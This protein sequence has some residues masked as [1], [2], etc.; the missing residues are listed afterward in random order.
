MFGSSRLAQ[1]FLSRCQ[2][3]YREPCQFLSSDGWGAVPILDLLS[4]G[5]KRFFFVPAVSLASSVVHSRRFRRGKFRPTTSQRSIQPPRSPCIRGNSVDDR[6]HAFQGTRRCESRTNLMLIPR[7]SLK[8]CVNEMFRIFLP[9]LTL[10]T[11][12]LQE[13]IKYSITLKYKNR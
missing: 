13:R 8:R 9:I 6:E 2:S 10:F 5:A 3:L 12:Y 11:Y 1:V 7:V 4:P